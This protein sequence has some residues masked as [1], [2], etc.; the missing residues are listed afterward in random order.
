MSV[1]STDDWVGEVKAQANASGIGMILVHE[2]VVRGASRSGEPVTS[3]KLGV[4]RAR[5]DEVLAEAA[6]WPGVLGL[7]AW[8]TEGSL[9]VGDTIMKVLVAGDIRENVFGGLQRL[10]G[11]IKNEVVSESELR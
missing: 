6:T 5:L 4:D 9:A 3:M 1:P 11:I 10:V 2:G 8:V 7:R